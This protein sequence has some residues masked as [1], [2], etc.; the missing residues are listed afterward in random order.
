M[1]RQKPISK[2]T[3]EE[4]VSEY[5]GLERWAADDFC[6]N[7]AG[8]REFRRADKL[9]AEILSRMNARTSNPQ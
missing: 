2:M 9:R 6:I 4:V 7:P 1:S 3:N 5:T 8:D